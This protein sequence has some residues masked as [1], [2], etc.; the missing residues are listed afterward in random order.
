[1]TA[2]CANDTVP[3]PWVDTVR[4]S[5]L[6]V[7]GISSKKIN[8]FNFLAP[9][10]FRVSSSS[11]VLVKTDPPCS[12]VTLRQLNYLLYSPCILCVLQFVRLDFTVATAETPVVHIVALLLVDRDVSVTERA[13]PGVRLDGLVTTVTLVRNNTVIVR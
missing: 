2:Q 1:M 10:T 7:F 12:A 6:P 11:Y 8:A 3:I 13:S 4:V 9:T 5:K